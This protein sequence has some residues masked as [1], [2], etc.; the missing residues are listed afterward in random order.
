[1]QKTAVVGLQQ[2]L[3]LRGS[4]RKLQTR[5]LERGKQGG[6]KKKKNSDS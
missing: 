5:G 1:M 6:V 3:G 4:S 2:K